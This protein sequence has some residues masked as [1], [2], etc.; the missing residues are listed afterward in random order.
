MWIGNTL[1]RASL[2]GALALAMAATGIPPDAFAQT[3]KR[4][5]IRVS[6]LSPADYKR[7]RSGAAAWFHKG[8]AQYLFINDD[9]GHIRAGGR[10]RRLRQI[11]PKGG[12][13]CI[14]ATFRNR[15]QGI[16]VRTARHR[17]AWMLSVATG[18]RRTRIVGLKCSSG[19]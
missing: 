9:G 1:L 12:Y 5:A 13:G 14:P 8:R 2:L 10:F 3:K 18:N 15:K 16:T 6:P 11:A 4:P 19:S 17:G 7:I